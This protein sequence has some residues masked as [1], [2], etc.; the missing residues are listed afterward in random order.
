MDFLALATLTAQLL[1]IMNDS[2]GGVSGQDSIWRAVLAQMDQSLGGLYLI[3]LFSIAIPSSSIRAHQIGLL[4][5]PGQ[6]SVDSIEVAVRP[7]WMNLASQEL[8]R[9]QLFMPP[10]DNALEFSPNLS[11][12]IIPYML[13]CHLSPAQFVRLTRA[14]LHRTAACS[15]ARFGIFLAS[16]TIVSS[17]RMAILLIYMENGVEQYLMLGS[18]IGR[19]FMAVLQESSILTYSC[20]YKCVSSWA[21]PVTYTY[22]DIGEEENFRNEVVQ[23]IGYSYHAYAMFRLFEVVWKWMGFLFPWWKRNFGPRIFSCFSSPSDDEFHPEEMVILRLLIKEHLE[24]S[25]T[26]HPKYV[27]DFEVPRAFEV[28]RREILIGEP[29]FRWGAICL[30]GGFAVCGVVGLFRGRAASQWG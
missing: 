6:A 18:E 1:P 20:G 28:A 12:F 25:A 11:M 9:G 17:I 16:I 27:V 30:C 19:W 2:Y 22:W 5:T 26:W 15:V 7:K 3:G 24:F 13:N 21:S 14:D 29:W 8:R 4:H 10:S 23:S